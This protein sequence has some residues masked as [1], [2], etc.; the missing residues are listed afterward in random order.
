MTTLA[1]V[2]AERHLARVKSDTNDDVDG[3]VDRLDHDLQQR[4]RWIREQMGMKEWSNKG[5]GRN[6]IEL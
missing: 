1:G 4:H 2:L 6:T 3:T 5:L